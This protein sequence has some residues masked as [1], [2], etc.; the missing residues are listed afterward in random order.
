[1]PPIEARAK[2]CRSEIAR[3]RAEADELLGKAAKLFRGQDF[4]AAFG[5]YREILLGSQDAVLASSYSVPVLVETV[6]AGAGITLDSKQVG[7][8]PRWVLLPSDPS[9]ELVLSSA[10]FETVSIRGALLGLLKANDHRLRVTLQPKVLWSIRDAG[11]TLAAGSSL[12]TSPLAVLGGDGV[13]RGI[14]PAGAKTRWEV[15]LSGEVLVSGG[16]LVTGPVVTLASEWGGV[17]AFSLAS[18]KH[19]WTARVGGGNQAILGPLYRGQLLG[20]IGGRVVLLNPHTG[21]LYREID[22]PSAGDVLQVMATGDTG[23]F[24]LTGGDLVLADLQSG[25]LLD[26]RKGFLRDAT[27][28]LVDGE[29]FLVLARDGMLSA[30]PPSVAR[31]LWEAKIGAQYSMVAAGPESRVLLGAPAGS[32]VCMDARRG[33]PMW[34]TTLGGSL[35]ALESSP[36]AV[37][38]RVERD[39]KTVLNAMSPRTGEVFWE[40]ETAPQEEFSVHVEEAY[41]FVS[42]PSRGVVILKT[43]GG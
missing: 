1:L 28:A 2:A 41:A 4:K 39:G 11:G 38:V 29:T 32:V 26:S 15:P 30:Y 36:E 5:A 3:R 21:L 40:L 42:T 7:R 27:L 43:P 18:G 23:L 31:R 6:P 20:A 33:Q 24:W 17:L 22:V 25:K 13:L 37:V 16:P 8:T 19:A 35:G 9:S 12:S 34:K 10:G 14:E